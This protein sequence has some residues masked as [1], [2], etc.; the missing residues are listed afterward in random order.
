MNTVGRPSSAGAAAVPTGADAAAQGHDLLAQLGSE[1]ASA[2]SVALERVN[3]IATTGKISWQGLRVLREQIEQAR[4]AG[5]MGQQV[6]RLA[7]GRVLQSPERLDLTNLLREALLQHRRQAQAKGL[8]VRQLLGP[9]QVMADPTLAFTLAEALLGWILDHARSVVEMRVELNEWPV[10]ARLRCHFRFLSD[11]DVDRSLLHF[12]DSPLR[13][14][15]WRLLEQVARTMELPIQLDEDGVTARL[16]IDFPRTVNDPSEL[17]ALRDRGDAA[18]MGVNSKP[19]AGN[20]LLVIAA[21][22]ETRALVRDAVRHMGLML[23]Y[24]STVEEAREF[25]SG[26]MPHAVLHESALGGE[27]FERLRMDLL[28][29]MPALAFI[30]LAEDGQGVQVQRVGTREFSRVSRDAIIESLPSA[31][32]FE[33]SRPR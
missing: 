17:A 5:I 19:L 13:T 6:Q 2:L 21:R 1:V 26:G 32:M 33:L 7:S 16:S 22:R 28:A 4:R 31:L 29:E 24:A 25:C 12:D 11:E 27:R 8:E 23:D 18:R 30:E 15:S 3:E 9:A 10:F 20:H 14:V